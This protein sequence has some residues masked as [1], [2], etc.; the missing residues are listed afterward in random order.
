METGTIVVSF[1]IEG[2]ITGLVG[3]ITGGTF[4][5]DLDVLVSE[6]H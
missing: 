4:L 1:G 3:Y 2:K 6:R 5:H